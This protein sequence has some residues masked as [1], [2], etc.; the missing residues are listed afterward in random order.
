MEGFFQ[1][2]RVERVSE[3]LCFPYPHRV[4]WRKNKLHDCTL[5]YGQFSEVLNKMIVTAAKSFR[6][7]KLNLIGSNQP[8]IGTI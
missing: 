8:L 6:F 3:R 1:G 4:C 5:H 7:H 2:E